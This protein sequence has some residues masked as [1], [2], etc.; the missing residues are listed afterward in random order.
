MGLRKVGCNLLKGNTQPLS[1]ETDENQE[2]SQKEHRNWYPCDSV[3]P[4]YRYATLSAC[5]LLSPN[6]YPCDSLQPHYRYATLSACLLL[7]PNKSAWRS[8]L[9]HEFAVTNSGVRREAS[10][11]WGWGNASW[12]SISSR[13]SSGFCC[14]GAPESALF[15]V[16]AFVASIGRSPVTFCVRLNIMAG[17]ASAAGPKN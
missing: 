4:H 14:L 2:E 5:L 1:E 12:R 10:V 15:S 8:A 9:D 17:N 11:L 16:A 6:W 3:Q 7:S 13:Y